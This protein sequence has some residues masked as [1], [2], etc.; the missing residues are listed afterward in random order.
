M[1]ETTL[2]GQHLM[3]CANYRGQG[4]SIGLENRAGTTGLTG[5]NLDVR[6]SSHTLSTRATAKWIVDSVQCEGQ[7]REIAIRR[8]IE[9]NE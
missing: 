5:R 2:S 9:S 4:E 1:V 6:Q 8:L 3:H 7:L